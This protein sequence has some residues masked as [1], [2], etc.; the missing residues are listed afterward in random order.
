M[1]IVCWQEERDLRW[2]PF[3][4]TVE[5]AA[6]EIKAEHPDAKIM[7]EFDAALNLESEGQ[8][9][10]AKAL[11]ERKCRSFGLEPSDWDAPL[12]FGDGRVGRLRGIAPGR[13]KYVFRCWMPDAQHYLLCPA[14]TVLK[15]LDD[16]RLRA[17]GAAAI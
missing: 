11:F 5:E 1:I 2:K 8:Y 16:A 17:A 4:G 14:S 7:Y 9:T 3:F 15:A 10:E 12:R 13:R 6:E